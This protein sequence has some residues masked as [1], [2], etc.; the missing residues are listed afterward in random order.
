[1]HSPPVA[2]IPK[3]RSGN[4]PY[5]DQDAVARLLLLPLSFYFSLKELN[6]TLTDSFPLQVSKSYKVT[7]KYDNMQAHTYT[8]VW[9]ELQIK[10]KTDADN[11]G[12]NLKNNEKC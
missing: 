4:V 2:F 6:M 5:Q 8:A 9:N 3:V 11:D 12:K 7:P 10:P 1:M